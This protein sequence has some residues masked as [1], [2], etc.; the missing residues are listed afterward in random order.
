LISFWTFITNAR[1]KNKHLNK[2]ARKFWV[3]KQEHCFSIS[4]RENKHLN[5]TLKFV[6]PLYLVGLGEG[7]WA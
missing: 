4:V 7:G 3:E 5:K 1:E 2:E 6:F